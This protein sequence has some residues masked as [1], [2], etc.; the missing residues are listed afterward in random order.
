MDVLVK[1]DGGS[2]SPVR[3]G[4]V[5]RLLARLLARQDDVPPGRHLVVE[6]EI[7]GTGG[8]QGNFCLLAHLKGDTRAHTHKHTQK[9]TNTLALRRFGKG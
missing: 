4:E 5:G 3:G 1:G 8:F 7:T 9:E 2:L 6:G